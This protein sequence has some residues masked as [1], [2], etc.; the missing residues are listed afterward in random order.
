[1]VEAVQEFAGMAIGDDQRAAGLFGAAVPTTADA[2]QF[3]ALLGH[4]GRR[5]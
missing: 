3:T 1:V 5:A 4:L 2:D